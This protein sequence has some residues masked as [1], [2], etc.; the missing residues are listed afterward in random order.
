MLLNAPPL[1]QEPPVKVLFTTYTG[2]SSCWSSTRMAAP[3]R[4]GPVRSQRLPTKCE[5]TTLSRPPRTK[6]APPPPPSVRW[7]VAS[8]SV[9][10]KFCTV[11]CGWSWLLQCEV[12][13]PCS[14]SQVFM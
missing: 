13:Q 8:P 6:I 4:S 7:P 2:W 14:M 3:P 9:K 11:N 5:L 1:A 10:V 12:V